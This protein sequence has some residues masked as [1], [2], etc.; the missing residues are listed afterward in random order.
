VAVNEQL[1]DK[2][3]ARAMAEFQTNPLAVQFIRRLAKENE[4]IFLDA[5]LKYMQDPEQTNAHRMLG[6]LL[7]RQ[8][9]LLSRIADP[10]A[11]SRANAVNLFR[12]FH[13]MD[14][15]FD[16]RLA[17]KLPSRGA[18]KDRGSFDGD[19]SGRAL[20]ILDETS[21]GRRLLPILGHLPDS[22]DPRISARATL[23]V[24]KRVQSAEW[25]ARQLTRSD[26]RIRANAVEALWGVKSPAAMK[27]FDECVGDAH[28]RVA[29]NAL[30]G[31]H[32]GGRED[33]LDQVIEMSHDWRPDRRITSAWAMGRLATDCFA[34]R[35]AEMIRDDDPGVRGMALRALVLIRKTSPVATDS[36]EQEVEQAEVTVPED[37]ISPQEPDLVTAIDVRLDGRNFR[38]G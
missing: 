28:N 30:V 38:A 1:V 24:G 2:Y 10:Q 5:G 4:D 34:D 35:L 23:F 33:A 19:K 3:L 20:D 18:W 9:S 7:L 17:R 26:A 15:A 13:A 31:L 27:L 36:Q 22:H 12:R 14:S 8:E 11:N 25:T 16:V 29:G 32:V 37:P 21:Q 6:L